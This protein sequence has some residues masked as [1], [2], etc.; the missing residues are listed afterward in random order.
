MAKILDGRLVQ[1]EI[2]KTLATARQ[3]LLFEPQLVIVQVGD[4]PESNLY[5]ER[6]RQ[7]GE[8]IGVKVTVTRYAATITE[9][10]LIPVIKNFNADTAVQGIIVQL[11]LPPSFPPARILNAV[12]PVKD[13]DGLS[14]GSDFQP[15]TARAVLTLL[16]YYRFP[17]AGREVV[18][19]GR[20]ALV[21]KPIALACLNAG[22]TVTVC[23]RQT[24]N[25]S[26][27]TG[28]AAI[29]IAAAGARG[30]ITKKHVRAG[31]VV[32]DVGINVIAAAKRKIVGDVAFAEVV[33]IVRAISPVPGGVGP[34]TIA[35][36]FENLLAA[37]KIRK[38][39][40]DIF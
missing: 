9:T 30:L 31:Q 1:V 34:L 17:L 35:C 38:P 2:K 25:L 7:F 32:I 39:A 6:K 26:A 10:E 33:K 27:V 15:A 24:K 5:I 19:V 12:D 18:V 22:A 13:V 37:C 23:H 14:A 21:G 16:N 36:L 40:R 20:S 3:R 8:Q 11:P 29:L 4:R 28:R